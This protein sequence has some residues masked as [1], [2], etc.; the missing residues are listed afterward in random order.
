[1]NGTNLF[2]GVYKRFSGSFNDNGGVFLS[3]DNGD[4]WT[5]VT[6]GLTSTNVQALAVNGTDLFAGTNGTGVFLSTNNGSGWTSV[7]NAGLKNI[8]AHTFAFSG[9]YLFAGTD[10]GGFLSTNNGANWT[11]SDTGL[12]HLKIQSLAVSGTN[13]Y[14]GTNG[15]GVFLS[16]DNG[17]SWK[18]IN[19]GLSILQVYSLAVSGTNLFAGTATGGA[20]GGTGMVYK[21]ALKNFTGIDEQHNAPIQVTVFPN[22]TTG[23]I[24]FEFEPSLKG[25]AQIDMTDILGK[26]VYSEQIT[27][28]SI[29]EISLS[30]MPKGIYFVR[31]QS[32]EANYIKKIIVQ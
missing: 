17:N 30:S 16:T 2:A 7:T 20:S 6:T 24:T 9:A 29:K 15:G 26:I 5:N 1:M 10:G 13:L 19:T 28:L 32:G 8:N 3:T 21:V 11:S 23:N 31:V 12:T 4:S 18:A 25:I 14:A 22:P 27:N